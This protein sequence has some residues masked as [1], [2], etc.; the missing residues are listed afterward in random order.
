MQAINT[1]HDAKLV[2]T[3]DI[4][5]VISQDSSLRIYAYLQLFGKTTPSELRER[6]ELAHASVFRNLALMTKVGLLT[7]EEDT[8]VADRRYRT[9]YYIH[10][11]LGELLK[12]VTA[13][14]LLEYAQ[15]RK[16]TELVSRWIKAW[17][18][19]P[20][21]LNQM[22]TQLLLS[23]RHTSPPGSQDACQKVT[24]IIGFHVTEEEHFDGLAIRLKEYIQDLQAHLSTV[25]RNWKEPLKH[26]IAI[27]IS[28]VTMNPEEICEATCQL[29]LP[30]DQ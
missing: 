15:E 27:A 1:D 6:T 24:K 18:T 7:K 13:A 10:Q 4:T 20:L 11:S 14:G 12:Q 28:M 2:R 3:K 5:Q 21:A 9:H 8:T 17:E 29:K 22:T 23:M 25:K 26:P 30:T 19:V 16:E